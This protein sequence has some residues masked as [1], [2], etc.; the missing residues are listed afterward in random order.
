MEKWSCVKE[1]VRSNTIILNDMQTGNLCGFTNYVRMDPSNNISAETLLLFLSNG[2]TIT[3]LQYSW[4]P[5]NRHVNSWQT[6]NL[7]SQALHVILYI[8]QLCT[9]GCITRYLV[10]LFSHHHICLPLGTIREII[11]RRTA[12]LYLQALSVCVDWALHTK[13]LCFASQYKALSILAD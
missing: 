5:A 6:D 10:K 1:Q 11:T 13:S 4:C 9:T 3:S 2:C 8:W 12:H 7:S